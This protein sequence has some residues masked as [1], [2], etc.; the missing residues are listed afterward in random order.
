MTFKS[1]HACPVQLEHPCMTR[2]HWVTFH[3][4]LN[5]DDVSI[6][7]I[8]IDIS[9]WH[10]DKFR[11]FYY[12]IVM[13]AVI[14]NFSLLVIMYSV[15]NVDCKD[16]LFELTSHMGFWNFHA[17]FY[18]YLLSDEKRQLI[19]NFCANSVDKMRLIIP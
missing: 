18:T 4:T 16:L 2:G 7:L 15:Q 17:R 9:S 3:L 11:L 10:L 19:I 1:G 5:W 6:C 8:L 13:V 14:R 12:F